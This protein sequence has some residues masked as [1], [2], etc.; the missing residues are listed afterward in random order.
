MIILAVILPLTTMVIVL[1]VAVV[2]VKQG[3][4]FEVNTQE[5][6]SLSEM[7]LVVYVEPVPTF[8]PFFFH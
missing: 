2:V 6:I 5:N 1:E 3:V 4:A 8:V 7:V